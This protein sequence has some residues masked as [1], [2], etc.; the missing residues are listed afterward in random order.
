[1]KKLDPAKCLTPIDTRR[2]YKQII[3]ID[4]ESKDGPTQRPGFTRVFLAGLYDGRKFTAFRNESPRDLPW[5]RQ[6]IEKGGAIDRMMRALLTRQNRGKTIYAHAGGTFD[7]LH[8]I[9][10]L[11]LHHDEFDYKIVPLQSAIQV[12]Q[13]TARASKYRFTFLDSLRL[14]PMGLD[15]VAKT[16]GFKGKL[17]HSLKK[18]EDHP[19]WVPYL[20]QDC[21]ALY[22]AVST[23]QKLVTD[24]LKGELGITAPS[25]AMLLFRRN[26][27]GR[28]KTPAMV[29]QHRHFP[30]CKSKE[31]GGCLHAFM[32]RGY[33]GGRVE[34]FRPKGS[35]LS[36]FDVNSSYP[37]A[38]LE[39]MPAGARVVRK[40]PEVKSQR[41]FDRLD[42]GN[43]GFVEC[44][45]EIPR[46]C[47]LPPLPY[48]EE[49]TGKLLFPVGRFS[50]VWSYEELKLL[51]HPLVRGRIVSVVQSVWITRSTLFFDFVK[52]LYPYRDKTSAQYDEGLALIAK[53][54]MNS[55]YGKFGMIEERRE[56]RLLRPGDA[57][58]E[59]ATLPILFGD[60]N[61]EEDSGEEDL[62]SRVIYVDKVVRAPYIIPQISAHITA[63]GRVR[64]WNFM[65]GILERKK[66][67]YYC[68]TDSLLTDDHQIPSSSELGELKNEFPGEKLRVVAMGPKMYMLSKRKPFLGEHTKDCRDPKV[69]KGCSR[70]KL[71]MKGIPKALRTKETMKTFQRGKAVYFKRLEKLGG[72]V[73]QGLREAPRLLSVHKS[74]K[75][76]D[77][78][79]ELLR[80]G[81][82]RPRFLW[83]EK[84]P[85]GVGGKRRKE[86]DI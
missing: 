23:F 17:D 18:H 21:R 9:P 78:K 68:D 4:L 85:G 2:K 36:Y 29:P 62:Q 3:V 47:Y 59:G 24:K 58:P 42:L 31:C 8:L 12:L 10:W 27:L 6:A 61:F 86:L 64:L 79:R 50:G 48:R 43:V 76:R 69:C 67:L 72:M 63:L 66:K 84:V 19:S 77:Q 51:R 70:D 49:K 38:M 15:K 13:V 22:Q 71:A 20:E 14:L 83:E 54:M 41:D 44:T 1:M 33:Y 11:T 16:F 57:M 82:T 81:N 37:R 32:R 26:F 35:G 53:L 65:A 30:K 7:H 39:S 75:T 40:G 25:T 60:N 74:V 45:V 73:Q 55:L 28:G 80:T 34:V 52:T 5:N 56:I 46:T